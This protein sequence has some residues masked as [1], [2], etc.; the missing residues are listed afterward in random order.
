[1]KTQEQVEQNPKILEIL[2]QEILIRSSPWLS[3]PEI[4]RP[5]DQ[6]ADRSDIFKFL[7]DLDHSEIYNFDYS[8]PVLEPG[9]NR[10]V[11]DQLVLVRGYLTRTIELYDR[12]P[13]KDASRVPSTVKPQL[14]RSISSPAAAHSDRRTTPASRTSRPDFRNVPEC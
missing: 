7:L 4:H 13:S 14:N 12:E 11:R 5:P 1:M 8:V 6:G 3:G 9:L 2:I 10:S